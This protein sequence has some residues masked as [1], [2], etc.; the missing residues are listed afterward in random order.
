MFIWSY[1]FSERK[2]CIVKFSD[3]LKELRRKHNLTQAE[4]TS[5]LFLSRSVIAKYESDAQKPTRE[6]IQKIALFFNVDL[7]Y[8]VGEDE[9]IGIV[10]D[11]DK[12]REKTKIFILVFSIIASFLFI[13]VFFLPIFKTYEYKYPVVVGETPERIIIF[14][15]SFQLLLE[16]NKPYGIIS[17]VLSVCVLIYSLL[18]LTVF[19]NKSFA[20]RLI[21]YI[22]L[23]ISLF[24]TFLTFAFTFGYA[25]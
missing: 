6:N 21:A 12:I 24:F 20:Y 22:I 19:K 14:K 11:N 5:K 1:Y 17:F 9:V 7:R 10:F 3:R 15:S 13:I 25:F 2:L 23:I 18:C 8:L 16:N 4:L